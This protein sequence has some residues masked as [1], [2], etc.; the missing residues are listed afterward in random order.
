VNCIF[1]V[2]LLYLEASLSCS[3]V[4]DSSNV[5]IIDLSNSLCLIRM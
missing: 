1:E 4:T 3:N 2:E 5:L